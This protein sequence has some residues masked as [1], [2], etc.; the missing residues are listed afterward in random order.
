MSPAAYLFPFLAIVF[1]AGNVIVSKMA[2]SAIA[3]TAITFYRLVLAIALLSPFLVR[4]IWRNR[5]AIRRHWWQLAIGGLLSMALFQ[6]LSYRAAESTTAT[7]MAIVTA[8]IPLLTAILSAALLGD[9]VT[10]GMAVGGVLSFGGILYL[11]GHG[12]IGAVLAQGA[13]LG[14]V[15]MLFAALAYSLYGVLLK[16]WRMAI[17]A[18]QSTYMQAAFALVFMFPLFLA[19]PAGTAMLDART[20]P[21]IAYAGIFSSIILTFFWIQGVKLLGPNRCAIFINLLPV[22]TA[23]LAIA[24][25]DEPMRAYHVIGGGI[26]LAGVL[27][28]QT[29]QRPLFAVRTSLAR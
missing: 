11:V 14:D 15:L 19:L 20:V 28:A 25:L 10:L 9:P 7:N 1:W 27:I 6:A 17:P 8:L 24:L 13:H 3:P 22:L 4:P 2:A 12:D 23:G 21:L 18:W 5:D 29:V 26:S 16:R